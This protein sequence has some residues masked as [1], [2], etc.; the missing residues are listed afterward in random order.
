ME[1]GSSFIKLNGVW[2]YIRPQTLKMLFFFMSITNIRRKIKVLELK[3]KTVN[4]VVN[5]SNKN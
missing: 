3:K 5:K 4:K 2:R 1:A